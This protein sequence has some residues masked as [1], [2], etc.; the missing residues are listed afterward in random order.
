MRFLANEYEAGLTNACDAFWQM[1]AVHPV[2]N[3]KHLTT[4]PLRQKKKPRPGGEKNKNESKGV[5]L[6]I[7]TFKTKG[8]IYI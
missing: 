2:W 3:F 6:R 1:S 7:H 4:L 5:D 8:S